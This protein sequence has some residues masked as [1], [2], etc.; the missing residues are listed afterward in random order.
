MFFFLLFAAHFTPLYSI[1]FTIRKRSLFHIFL[2]YLF[3][4]LNLLRTTYAYLLQTDIAKVWL[5]L[6]ITSLVGVYYPYYYKRTLPLWWLFSTSL[7]A[8]LYSDSWVMCIVYIVVIMKF[9]DYFNEGMDRLRLPAGCKSIP[10]VGERLPLI[11][12]GKH[13]QTDIIRFVK[14]CEAKYG[15]IF[16]IQV[17]NCDMVVCTS[18]QFVD[19]FFKQRE[20]T[21]SLVQVLQRLYFGS[22]F[23]DDAGSLPRIIK[24]VKGSIAVDD[25]FL[26]KIM[27]EAQRLAQ[28]LKRLAIEKRNTPMNLSSEMIRF[29]ACTSARCFMNMTL[30][31][32]FYFALTEFTK[33]LNHI[34]VL[35]YFM[36]RQ[37]LRLIYGRRLAN[38]RNCMTNCM[39]DEIEAYRRDPMK[40]DSLVFRKAVD[41]KLTNQQVGEVI[42]CLL[43]V[44]SEN[45]ALGLAATMTDLANSAKLSKVN[46]GDRV[47]YWDLVAQE[48]AEFLERQDMNGIF[49]ETSTNSYACIME[50]AR[51]TS[52]VFALNRKPMKDECTLGGYYIPPEV[53]G[54]GLC[55]PLLMLCGDA[56]KVKFSNPGD[57]NP[58]RYRGEQPDSFQDSSVMTWGAGTHRCPGKNF[59][60]YEIRAALAVLTTVFEPFELVEYGRLD[61]FSPS[62]F[63]ERKVRVILNPR[64][65]HDEKDV[66]VASRITSANN[67]ASTNGGTDH[68]LSGTRM[69]HKIETVYSS[70]KGE[71]HS[72]KEVQRGWIL[73]GYLSSADQEKWYQTLWRLS[74]GTEEHEILSKPNANEARAYALFSHNMIYLDNTRRSD[75]SSASSSTKADVDAFLDHAKLVWNEL[76]NHQLDG[77]KTTVIPESQIPSVIPEFDSMNALLF[78]ENAKMASHKDQ[79]VTWGVSYNLGASVNFQ[80]GETPLNL[81]SGDILVADFSKV[82]HAVTAIHAASIPG[83]WSLLASEENDKTFGKSRCSIQIRNV[84]NIIEKPSKYVTSQEFDSILSGKGVWIKS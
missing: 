58:A 63:A 31:E 3:R 71:C 50:S 46:A 39:I 57:Y 18:A 82:E 55:E 5:S 12:H 23:S 60:L 22:A 1:V 45:T 35:T 26:P 53:D 48:S 59:A 62:A 83:W 24:L 37:L 16:R 66:S 36:P 54:V 52:H 30:T 42:V 34:V 75:K 20:P 8:L 7:F 78:G 28:R 32:D 27:I 67:T 81:H 43:Y 40:R 29:V 49:K 13:F 74:Q 11:G 14:A 65:I 41:E 44:S 51:M 72:N 2:F 21:M 80:F 79:Y 61:Y 17:W 6:F 76:L 10:L 84:S 33:L 69:K 19:T 25:D 73:R 47:N 64:T 77:K 9:R 15:P 70:L 38:L 4:M 56:A 68:Y